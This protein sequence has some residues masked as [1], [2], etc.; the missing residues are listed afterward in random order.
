[1]KTTP[2]VLAL[3]LVGTAA[4]AEHRPEAWLDIISHYESMRVAL[5][6]DST[7]GLAEHAA[8]VG[9]EADKL[10]LEFDAVRAGVP[11]ERAADCQAL[12]PKIAAAAASVAKAS[13]IAAAREA[14]HQ[15][16][17]PLVEYRDMVAA[18]DRPVVVYCA[19]AKKSWLQPL[20]DIGNPYYGKSM[21]KCGQVI[22]K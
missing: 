22:S 3:L 9:A 2:I 14:F 6:D 21:E 17:E 8:A 12:M 15:L 5:V 11:A 7:E 10:A 1:M 20:G 4:R 19:M 13:D 18:S 16:S